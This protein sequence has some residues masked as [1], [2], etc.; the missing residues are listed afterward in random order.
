MLSGPET[1]GH[2]ETYDNTIC[3]QRQTLVLGVTNLSWY[4]WTFAALALKF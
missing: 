1:T 2:Q 3:E 4:F